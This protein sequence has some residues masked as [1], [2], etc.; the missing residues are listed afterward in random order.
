MFSRHREHRGLF[1]KRDHTGNLLVDGKLL[2]ET[3]LVEIGC[4]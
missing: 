4:M 3:E 2:L 1:S